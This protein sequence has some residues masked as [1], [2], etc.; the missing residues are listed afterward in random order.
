MSAYWWDKPSRK[1]PMSVSSHRPGSQIQTGERTVMARTQKPDRSNTDQHTA[2][3]I[4]LAVVLAAII[5]AVREV[6]PNPNE[7]VTNFYA[8][9]IA[10]VAVQFGAVG[11]AIAAL[12]SLA[13]F[14][15]WEVTSPDVV[16]GPIGYIS[17][18]LA[19]LVLGVIV[20]RFASERR[21]LVARLEE[22]AT[23]DPLTGVANRRKFSADF[24]VELARS[25][26][27]KRPGALLLA[28]LDGFKAVNDS[29]GHRAGDH[30]LK[31]VA[32]ILQQHVR[33]T[34]MVGR[35][36]GDEFVV[37]LPDTTRADANA[38]AQKL[39]NAV[40]EAVR[41]VDGKPIRLGLSI[42][43]VCFDGST[44]HSPAELVHA[45]DEAMYRNKHHRT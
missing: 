14:A 44:P 2:F 20:G 13:L 19:F 11:G 33:V 35:I 39:R 18:G 38:V 29:L 16:V 27:H 42:G 17:R 41:E 32:D 4:A 26:R 8:I 24:A 7:G 22:L 43:C 37:L 30:V 9:P 3:T 45:A 5:Y 36:G 15:E 12:L 6:L 25:R 10:I 21:A 34:D 40:P 1:K 23:T 28:D 31:R